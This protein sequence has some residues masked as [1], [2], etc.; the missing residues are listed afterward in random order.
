MSS[1][2]FEMREV[3]PEIPSYTW[4]VVGQ[5][6]AARIFGLSLCNYCFTVEQNGLGVG[7]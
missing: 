4:F 3:S 6:I 5:T 7:H 1:T 2:K